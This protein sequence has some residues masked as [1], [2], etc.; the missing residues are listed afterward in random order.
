MQTQPH[1]AGAPA[2][3]HK[4]TVTLSLA[5]AGT[6]GENLDIAVPIPSGKWLFETGKKAVGA[7]KV[8]AKELAPVAAVVARGVAR[9]ADMAANQLNQPNVR[10]VHIQR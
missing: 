6:R 8:A 5:G 4:R 3:Q 1:A 7:A 9:S 2:S 10:V